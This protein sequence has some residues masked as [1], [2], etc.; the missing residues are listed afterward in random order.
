MTLGGLGKK[1]LRAFRA[2][3]VGMVSQN[4][5][6][7]LNPVFRI[8]S[9]VAETLRV[10]RGLSKG[11]AKA[12]AIELLERVGIA[13]PE[14]RYLSYPHELS[15]GMCQRVAIAIATASRPRLLLADEPT[16]A[17]DV[18]TQEQILKLLA[19]MRRE[20]GTS[21]LLV[22]HDF[23]VI[24]QICD[25]V[26]VMYGGH[27]VEVGSVGTIYRESEHPYTRALLSSIP[28]LESAGKRQRRSPIAGHPPELSD[29]MPGCV[30]EPRCRFAQPGCQSV[31]M[32]LEPVANG[33][34]T[35]CPVR[36]FA[37][38]ELLETR[39]SGAEA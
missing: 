25:R 6:T 24:A 38:T 1:Q 19:E 11:A 15:G 21:I 20:H 32:K 37:G 16:T 8:G 36:P 34:F 27:V 28:E 31:P 3:S 13:D 5:F 29:V 35:A 2:Q 39:K 9:Q 26:A 7:S 14:K 17:L 33:H 4:P 30:F 18:T 12:E 22:S 23:G 10:N